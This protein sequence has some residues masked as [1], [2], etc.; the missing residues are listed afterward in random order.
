MSETGRYITSNGY[1]GHIFDNAQG[2][3]MTEWVYDTTT[4]TLVAAYVQHDRALDKWELASPDQLADLED[5]I[6]NANSDAL[7]NPS[8]WEL[9]YSDELPNWAVDVTPAPN[10]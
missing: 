6:K 5:S 1:W 9:A 2:E 10:F 3:V 7:D 4:E 8:A